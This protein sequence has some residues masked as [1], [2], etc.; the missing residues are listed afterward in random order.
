MNRICLSIL[1]T[2]SYF[3][4]F[5]QYMSGMSQSNYSGIIGVHYNPALLADSRYKLFVNLFSVNVY[6]QNNY[7]NLRTPYKQLQVINGKLDSSY[8]DSNGIALFDNSMLE[9]NAN[10]KRKY[11][12]FSTDIIGPSAMINLK[13]KSGLAFSFR[14]RANAYLA[15]LDNSLMNFFFL[16]GFD[17]ATNN[18]FDKENYQKH[19]SRTGSKYKAGGGVNIFRQYT[20]TYSRVLKDGDVH[21]LS[22]GLSLSYLQGMGAVFI[23]LNEFNYKQPAKDSVD[24][25]GVDLEY[26]YINPDFFTRKPPPSPFNYYEGNKL[27][28][29]ASMDIGLS[30]EHRIK[31]EKYIYELDK[32]MHEDRSMIKYTYRLGLSLV[33]WGSVNYNNPKFVQHVRA[34]GDTTI[35]LKW[36]NLNGGKQFKNVAEVDS[37]INSLFPVLD[38]T[39]SFKAKLPTALHFMA[40]V[41]LGK[42]FFAGGQYT[43]SIR[44]RKKE[45][46]KAR[47]VLILS[48]RYESKNFEAALNFS[49]GNFYK[50]MQVGLFLRGGPFFIGSDNLGS[51]MG[52]KST[53]GLSLYTGF[54]V[55][56][57]YR[58]LYD[59]DGDKISNKLDKCP[60]EKGSFK[61]EGCP[62]KDADGVPDKEDECPKEP[63]RKTTKGCPDDDKDKVWSRADKCPTLPGK[64]ENAGCPDTDGDGLFDHKDNCPNEA[65]PKTN[66]GC[67]VVVV[68]KKPEPKKPE[69][70]KPEPKK[71]EMDFAKFYYYPVVGVFGIKTNAEN[72]SKTFSGKTGVKTSI[73]F[74][75]DKKLYYVTTGKLDNKEAAEKVIKKLDE[76]EINSLV[77]GKVWMYPEAR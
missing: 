23:R 30:Y 76:P 60:D 4:V 5:S 52:T 51:L 53:N 61:A 35:N 1:L 39:T 71:E 40:D 67:P 17:T 29:G 72:F 64:K 37:F 34:I 3:Q 19:T 50:K 57:A 46:I 66:G 13:D 24:I 42:G 63:G 69:P 68:A 43:Q 21:F 25:K 36:S 20:A 58:R 31:K 38:S 16:S 62:D 12:F 18:Y 49:F 41:N 9:Q 32:N 22:G 26:G 44:S 77:N 54:S 7:V 15:N 14:V 73:F 2:I 10:G 75:V 48:S 65:G 8:L 28:G 74:N 47:N 27:G 59:N 11:M 6:A 56:I 45:G 70:K 33:D 55:P